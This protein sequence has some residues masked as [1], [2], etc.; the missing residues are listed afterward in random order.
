[1]MSIAVSTEIRPSRFFSACIFGMAILMALTGLL[2][3]S[4]LIG[5]FRFWGRLSVFAISLVS[6][7]FFIFLHFCSKKTFRV[8]ISGSGKIRLREEGDH[9]PEP[10]SYPGQAVEEADD[11]YLANDSTV[12]PM[13]LLLCLESESGRKKSIMVFPDSVREGEF[14]ALYIACQWLLVHQNEGTR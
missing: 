14:Q 1:M 8:E 11:F 7:A 2:V 12:W 10:V 4:E 5:T 6:A 3:V 9:M 13:M